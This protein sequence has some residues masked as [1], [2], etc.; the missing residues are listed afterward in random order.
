MKSYNLDWLANLATKSETKNVS[1][2]SLTKAEKISYLENITE[3]EGAKKTIKKEFKVCNLSKDA[4]MSLI[5]DFAKTGDL[6]AVAKIAS[7]DA[8][9]TAKLDVVTEYA[10]MSD[11]QKLDYLR[12]CHDEIG[13]DTKV[14]V[15][16]FCGSNVVNLLEAVRALSEEEFTQ[17]FKAEK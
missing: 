8:E 11:S 17:I 1:F 14:D 12:G 5:A 9:F 3:T 6:E 16:C 7:N 13:D 10:K 4:K 2:S 15:P